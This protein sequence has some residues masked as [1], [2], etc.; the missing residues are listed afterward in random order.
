M[1]LI[2]S[3]TPHAPVSVVWSSRGR[4][5]AV[6]VERCP[7]CQGNHHL[8]GG[9]GPEPALGNR[10]ARCDAHDGS[11]DLIETEA[12]IAARTL[13]HGCIGPGCAVAIGLCQ[14]AH[15]LECA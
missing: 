1:G 7:L 5:W 4:Y 6:T 3:H 15:G 13:P 14:R 11:Y 8:G 12:S 10:V 2:A 9:D